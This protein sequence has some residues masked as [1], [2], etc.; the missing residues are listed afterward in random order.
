MSRSRIVLISLVVGALAFAV[1]CSF[2]P[3][4]AT[5]IFETSQPQVPEKMYVL[6]SVQGEM[7][8]ERALEIA[9]IFGISGQASRVH[10]VWRVTGDDNRYVEVHSFGGFRYFSDDMHY[11]LIPPEKYPSDERCVEMANKFIESLRDHG[12][13]PSGLEFSYVDVVADKTMIF[14]TENKTTT[15]YWNN[16]HVNYSLSYDDVPLF[17]GM[18]KVRVYLNEKGEVVGFFGDFWELAPYEEIRI[19]SPEKAIQKW[20]GPDVDKVVVKSIELVYYIPSAG[21][22]YIK[23][24]YDVKATSFTSDGEEVSFVDVIPAIED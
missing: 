2:R 3:V 15:E 4:G 13:A 1:A 22:A 10:D 17:G 12:F 5:V 7:N 16:K 21:A 23:P 14:S 20:L 24:S 9:S 19:L 11:G 6:K 18:A 8:E